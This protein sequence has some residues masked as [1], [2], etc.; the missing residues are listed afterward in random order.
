MVFPTL[1]S[2]TANGI[3]ARF[4]SSTERLSKDGFGSGFLKPCFYTTGTLKAIDLRSGTW[5]PRTFIG[6]HME[7]PSRHRCSIVLKPKPSLTIK[8][9][10]YTRSPQILDLY[11]SCVSN[12]LRTY[13]QAS[14]MCLSVRAMCFIV[15][16]SQAVENRLF[17]LMGLSVN[18]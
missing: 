4:C 2:S 15:R 17:S 5:I 3:E 12:N 1:R 8:P 6:K 14:A 7:K 9:L 16:I 11:K 13:L 18:R 10:P